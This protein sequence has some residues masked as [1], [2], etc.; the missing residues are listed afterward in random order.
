MLDTLGAIMDTFAH[1]MQ[2]VTPWVY[3]VTILVVGCI[4]AWLYGN[5]SPTTSPA[6]PLVLRVVTA[7]AGIW[8]TALIAAGSS[9][10]AFAPAALAIALIACIAAAYYVDFLRSDNYRRMER[11]FQFIALAVVW[12]TAVAMAGANQVTLWNLPF[13]LIPIAA[14]VV[15]DYTLYLDAKRNPPTP[16]KYFA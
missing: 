16:P 5:H 1:S 9:S 14:V 3:G 7:V 12:V 11:D 13:G 6:I 15:Y 4:L 10:D 2:P 8:L